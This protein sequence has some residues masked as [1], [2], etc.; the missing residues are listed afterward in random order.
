MRKGH[1]TLLEQYSSF[2]CQVGSE[3]LISVRKTPTFPFALRFGV[4][5]LSHFV[6]KDAIFNELNH[7]IY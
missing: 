7:M 4:I 5:I 2:A 3:F 1:V 6:Q